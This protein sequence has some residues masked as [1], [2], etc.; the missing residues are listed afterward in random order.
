MT[1]AITAA[2]I[3]GRAMLLAGRLNE[4]DSVA[5]AE[6]RA[7]SAGFAGASK[8]VL[9][10]LQFETEWLE[11]LAPAGPQGL[12]LACGNALTTKVAAA[13]TKIGNRQTVLVVGEN[14]FAAGIHT[15]P[16]TIAALPEYPFRQRPRRAQRRW[17]P[18]CIRYQF[19]CIHDST[20]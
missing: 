10:D 14:T 18:A 9:V 4:T 15:G 13:K 3:N 6:L 1:A 8:T 19:S 17:L 16:T 11:A 12:P 5:V 2:G 7:G 20:Y